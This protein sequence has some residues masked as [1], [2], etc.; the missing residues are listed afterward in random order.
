MNS[1][2]ANLFITVRFIKRASA[3]FNLIRWIHFYLQTAPQKHI[4]CLSMAKMMDELIA[5]RTTLLK[6]LK[7][8]QDQ[9]SWQ[10]FFDTYWKLIYDIA[11]KGGLT[12][13][14][15]EDVVQETMITVARHMPNF[16]YDRTLGTFKGWLFNLTR[17]RI[18]DQLRKRK[19]L[20]AIDPSDKDEAEIRLKKD[21]S[22]EFLNALWDAEW[23]KSLFDA[24]VMKVRRNLDPQKFQIFDFCV[25]KEW[26]P[27]KIAETFGIPT[28]QVYL[29]KHRVSEMIA[30]EV[31][32]LEMK[33]D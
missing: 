24:A 32:K 17:W 20:P 21:P 4:T 12:E 9:P 11:I 29:A 1:R 18:S 16:K 10:D 5:T 8:W 6:R 7:D 15:A 3:L 30:E 2:I 13:V 26:P 19:G 27:D 25:N 14:E 28:S 31:K 22:S 33:M 23:E